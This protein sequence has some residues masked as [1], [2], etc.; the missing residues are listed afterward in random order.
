MAENI[1]KSG[2]GGRIKRYANVTTKMSSLAFKLAS[3]RYLGFDI[4]R[5]KHAEELREALGGL[6]GPLMK[7]AQIL[8]TIPDVLPPEYVKKL[9]TLQ[10]D[11]PAMGWLFVKRR[12]AAELGLNWEDKYAHFE[13]QAI[14][15][16]SLG[17]VHKAISHDGKPLAVKLQYPDM[18]SAIE[19]D[20]NQL[21]FVFKLYERFENTI[22]TNEMYQEIADRLYE[23]LDYVNEAKNL[24]LYRL[25]LADEKTVSIPEVIPA[26][27]SDKLLS[28]TW[29]EGQK[30]MNWI[31]NEP[32]QHERNKVAMNMFR[33]WY[34][35]FYYYGV[36]HGDPHLGNYSI[37]DDL[38]INLMDFGAVRVFKPM[39]VSGVID[40]YKAL[41]D[42][43]RKLAGEAYEKWGFKNLDRE[44][45]E[46][47]NLWANFI[48]SPLLKDEVRP[49]Q[50]V[51]SGDEGKKLV[52]HVRN[53][54]KR[55]GRI[56]PPPEFVLMDRAAV[57]L[58]SVFLHL[59]AE[60]NWHRLFHELIDDFSTEELEK[61]Q[62]NA[63]TNVGLE[64]SK[65][66]KF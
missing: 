3:E 45:I 8:S 27:S 28:M 58:G 62:Y 11:A 43:N 36:I 37:K 48:Y 47:L 51:R 60:V 66:G 31:E 30:L 59:K 15:A 39:F 22:S 40:L 52:A 34:I 12:M 2:V 35:P 49:I 23:E 33:A 50:E 46:V 19:A 42:K 18:A 44:T 65:L 64:T 29:L 54:L 53:E 32:S 6:K 57:G 61:R 55:I 38:G 1:G 17:Q 41:R 24:N 5:T 25:M 10:A 63:C 13:R 9:E 56:S 14:S 7:V 4:N 20:L 16:A 21:R 26:L